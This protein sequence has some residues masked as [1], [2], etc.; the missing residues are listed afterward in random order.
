MALLGSAVPFI[1]LAPNS[2]SRGKTGAVIFGILVWVTSALVIVAAQDG[3]PE[4]DTPWPRFGA[5]ADSVWRLIVRFTFLPGLQ[6]VGLVV[7]P[8]FPWIGLAAF[9]FAS[10]QV[11][12]AATPRQCHL[13]GV[14]LLTTFLLIRVAGP[15]LLN[16]RGYPR[17]EIDGPARSFFTLSKYPPD[18][19]YLTWTM[20]VNMCI[21]GACK[22]D[23]IA[24][25]IPRTRSAAVTFGSVAL[26]FYLCHEAVLTC[27][28]LL[29]HLLAWILP[30][31][32]IVFAWILLLQGLLGPCRRY[33]NFKRSTPT[34]SLWRLL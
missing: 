29:S 17:G 31:W 3:V 24:D 5:E 9:G 23:S 30:W 4:K 8:V 26:F 32:L 25:S 20:G 22:S 10:A 15:A 14:S 21:M 11:L 1:T 28:G 18:A 27:L 16:F 34:D 19:S 2:K 13:M 12:N 7:Y 6:P 33:G